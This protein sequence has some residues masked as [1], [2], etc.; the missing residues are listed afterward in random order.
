M[1]IIECLLGR[2]QLAIH[3][4]FDGVSGGAKLKIIHFLLAIS[5]IFSLII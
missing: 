2:I 5:F 3:D 4:D 1:Y